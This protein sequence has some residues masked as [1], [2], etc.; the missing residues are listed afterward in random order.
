MQKLT[1]AH[2]QGVPFGHESVVHC[3]AAKVGNVVRTCLCSQ[4]L[5][6]SHGLEDGDANVTPEP[7]QNEIESR[8]S[9]GHVIHQTVPHSQVTYPGRVQGF[10]V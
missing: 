6:D 3:Q 2:D 4:W 10:R 7:Q 5:A 8:A 1:D 9:A